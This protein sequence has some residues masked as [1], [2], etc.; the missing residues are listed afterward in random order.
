MGS[1]PNKEIEFLISRRFQQMFFKTLNLLLKTTL[2]HWAV[3]EEAPYAIKWRLKLQGQIWPLRNAC[4][5][6]LPIITFFLNCPLK[7]CVKLN[8]EKNYFEILDK[9][10]NFIMGLTPLGPG[11]D[12]LGYTSLLSYNVVMISRLCSW[13]V[14]DASRIIRFSDN[15]AWLKKYVP[16]QAEGS[17]NQVELE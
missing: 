1:N 13:A 5:T 17:E 4:W 2:Y 12:G 11:L 6:S 8:M 15:V 16:E 9:L 7:Y 14:D 10:S 3:L